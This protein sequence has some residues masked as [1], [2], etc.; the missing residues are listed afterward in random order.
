MSYPGEAEIIL[1]GIH[2]KVIHNQSIHYKSTALVKSLAKSDQI[3]TSIH[4]TDG[5]GL[6]VCGR[7]I[8][9]KRRDRRRKE[10]ISLGRTHLIE[11]TGSLVAG[12]KGVHV[13]SKAAYERIITYKKIA[14]ANKDLVIK[15]LQGSD[16]DLVSG[17]CAF[18]CENCIPGE[19]KIKLI[20]D[21]FH[22]KQ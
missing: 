17:F 7:N 4:A 2:L 21:R 3:Y 6:S 14:A 20:A 13:F 5:L 9:T 18:W 11:N 12:N 8:I 22:A 15:T 16:R 1:T 19:F 10:C